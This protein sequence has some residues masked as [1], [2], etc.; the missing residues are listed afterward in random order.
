MPY[1]GD[2]FHLDVCKTAGS[3]DGRVQKC[4]HFASKKIV[5]NEDRFRVGSLE[6]IADAVYAAADGMWCQN[7]PECAATLDAA[8]CIQDSKCLACIR[9]WLQ[10]KADGAEV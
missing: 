9:K 5:T 4:K 7:L 6:E 8:E 2:C 3:C 10:E 1:C